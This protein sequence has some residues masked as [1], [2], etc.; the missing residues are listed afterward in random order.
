MQSQ[1]PVIRDTSSVV[2]YTFTTAGILPDG[3]MDT[4]TMAKGAS[5]ALIRMFRAAKPDRKGRA[6]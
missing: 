2:K 5:Y 1:S 6:N 4:F 3:I